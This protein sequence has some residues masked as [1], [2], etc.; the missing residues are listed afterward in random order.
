LKSQ[1]AVGSVLLSA[2]G[3]NVDP[4]TRQE[5]VAALQRRPL[6]LRFRKPRRCEKPHFHGHNLWNVNEDH[7]LDMI[8]MQIYATKKH[9]MIWM[10]F[11]SS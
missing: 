1:V 4:L 3:I 10:T 5:L 9:M 7:R 2:N 11:G 6:C 8:L